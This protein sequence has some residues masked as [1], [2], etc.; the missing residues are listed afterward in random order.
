MLRVDITFKYCNRDVILSLDDT[1]L[2]RHQL[3][4]L[5]SQLPSEEE[6]QSLRDFRELSPTG[7][8]LNACIYYN[9]MWD[10]CISILMMY[11]IRAS[12]EREDWYC[13]HMYCMV[14]ISNNNKV[15]SHNNIFP[16][17][18]LNRKTAG[19]G[20]VLAGAVQH[21]PIH[22]RAASMLALH[23]RIRRKSCAY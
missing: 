1:K 8:M 16:P 6:L 10:A 17:N 3:V 19:A 2:G 13:I 4:N 20:G 11:R 15:K 9:V 22:P 21:D 18:I 23:A 12:G 5:M 7:Y 14:Y